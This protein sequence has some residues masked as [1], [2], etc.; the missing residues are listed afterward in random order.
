MPLSLAQAVVDSKESLELAAAKSGS[1]RRILLLV[2]AITLHNIPEGCTQPRS[3]AP[4]AAAASRDPA[5]TRARRHSARRYRRRGSARARARSRLLRNAWQ[6]AD[7]S[8]A[9][10]RGACL[11]A[12]GGRVVW[13]P[14]YADVREALGVQLSDIKH[15]GS[16]FRPSVSSQSQYFDTN[17]CTRCVWMP[18]VRGASYFASQV[19]LRELLQPRAWYW[20]PEL[21]RRCVGTCKTQ[22]NRQGVTLACSLDPVSKTL[23]TTHCPARGAQ[24]LRCPCRCAAP[25][26]ASSR[27]SS[28]ARRPRVHSRSTS[29]HT[30]RT[31][32]RIP[33]AVARA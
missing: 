11:Q 22:V 7:T 28:T 27:R 12:G 14:R 20:Y 29:T 8:L 15:G 13:Q 21:S 4:A 17:T 1:W 31:H 18:T 26:L 33:P 3:A 24:A 6:T 19:Q 9:R 32:T 30:R 10:C 2:F 25:A 23:A 5:A 16:A